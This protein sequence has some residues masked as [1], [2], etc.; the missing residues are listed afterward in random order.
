MIAGPDAVDD[1]P[2]NSS[3]SRQVGRY[4]AADPEGATVTLSLTGTNSDEFN[5]ASNGTLT[6][7]DSPDYEAP[8][9]DSYRVT[10]Q[11]VAGSHTVDKM[12]TVNI[13]NLEEPGTVSLSAVQPQAGT[14]L[15]ATLDDDDG[16]TGT[17][18]QWYRTSSRGSTGSEITNA[19][20][21]LLHTPTPTTWAATCA[22][23]P[24]TTT[25]HGTG[26]TADV[27]S[28]NRVQE[29]AAGPGGTRVPGGR[30]LRPHHPREPAGWKE[31]RRA[32]HSHR[33]QQRPADLHRRHLRLLRDRR[34]HRPVAHQGRA[35]PRGSMAHCIPSR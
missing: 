19:D 23:L 15:T 31:H 18:W 16:P 5:L 33:C 26:K 1:F 17:T 2:E 28:A 12:V 35:R 11:A 29:A 21:R 24:P 8:G 13:Q 30:R 14:L 34:L 3:I 25:S 9:G 7:K 27:V 10:V 6:F 20:V 4:T 22:P 32:R